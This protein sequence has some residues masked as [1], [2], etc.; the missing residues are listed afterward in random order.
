MPHGTSDADMVDMKAKTSG[1]H[2]QGMTL[3]EV[4]VVIV[5]LV[6]LVS[7]LLPVKASC[8]CKSSRISCIN[9]MKQIGTAYRIWENDNGGKFPMQQVEE[10]GGMAELLLKTPN[11]G[12]YSYLVYSIMQNEMGQSPKIVLCPAD[13]RIANTNFYYNPRNAPTESG[14]KSPVPGNFGTFDNT[15]VSYFCGVGASDT[16]PESILGGDRNLG[17]NGFLNR[18]TGEVESSG[19]DQ[20]FGISGTVASSEGP[21]GADAIVNTNGNWVSAIVTGGGGRVTKGFQVGWSR[22]MHSVG[23]VAGAGNI[24]LGDGS[25]QQCTSAG[26]R[27][28]WI[29]NAISD[30]N[31]STNDKI[32]SADRGDIRLLF[33]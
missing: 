4:L 9:N 5:V 2:L 25:A 17:D 18:A 13:A 6:V 7:M 21:C 8:H 30:G 19:Q 26:L 1:C 24:M 32:H 14:L 22:K 16:M 33:P 10:Q 12:R 3:I 11:A 23:N 20:N 29:R 27:Q 28:N 15:D 31:F